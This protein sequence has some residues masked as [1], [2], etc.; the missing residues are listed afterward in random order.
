MPF[1]TL[2]SGLLAWAVAGPILA[3]GVV[4]LSMLT[5]E[6]IVVSGAVRVARG[7]EIV[8]CNAQL[9]AVATTINDAARRSVSKAWEAA[10][11]VKPVAS[12]DVAALCQSSASCRERA[13]S[14]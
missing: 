7:E 5:R 13:V 1:L 6:T 12:S 4:Y 2:K 10:A 9:Q 11:T 14:K 3:G 8:K